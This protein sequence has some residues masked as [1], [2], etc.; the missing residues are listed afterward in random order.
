MAANLHRAP[1]RLTW[2]AVA[3]G[4]A[5]CALAAKIGAD[6]R[7][8]AAI[9]AQIVHARAIP[10]AVP[11]AAAPSHGW[12]DAPALGQLVF[13]GLEALLG[14][15][16]LVLAQV[17]AVAAAL[18]AIAVD[19]RNAQT[20]DS[21]RAAVLLALLFAAPAALLVVRAQLFSLALFPLLVLLLRSETRKPSRRVWLT[22]PLIGL[23]ANLHGGVL[24]GLAVAGV[25][26]VLHRIRH[27]P[28][29]AVSIL[30][31]SAVAVLATPALFHTAG[32]Y[33]GVLRG[34]AAAR[35]YGL[36]APLSLHEPLDLVFLVV[37][38]PL[39]V[40]ALRARPAAWE[41]LMLALLAVMAVE[42]RRNEVW[43]VFFAATP[44]ARGLTGARADVSA[45]PRRLALVC[46]CVP[47]L[48]LGL[49]FAGTS[50]SSGAGRPLV[51]QA[52]AVAR[53]TPILADA[54]NAEK[55]ALSGDRIWIGN[56][57]DA[58]ARPDQLLYLEWL[59]GDPAGDAILSSRIQAAL[60]DLDTD[61][62]RRLASDPAFREV[63]RDRHAALYL[64]R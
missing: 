2:I 62:Q 57:L 46:G 10:A 13:H 9:G 36:W 17:V 15:R 21:A 53:G 30:A 29:A 23:W 1:A 50:A 64:R 47:V 60:V 40:A 39:L 27:D 56:P 33:A 49:A 45:L 38:V 14:D 8:L 6:A 51:Q 24:V 63:G 43:L 3:F 19:M 34:E 25:Y 41:L 58:F 42:A 7:W 28:A 20:R 31:A 37:A 5:A 4:C 48:M 32:Y 22:V 26:L 18:V 11:Y 55:L 59:R 61:T 54:L 12:H 44:A 16:G 52:G 35:H